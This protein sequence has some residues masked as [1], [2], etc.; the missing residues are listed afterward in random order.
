MLILFLNLGNEFLRNFIVYI[1]IALMEVLDL[2]DY[3]YEWSYKEQYNQE[4]KYSIEAFP[5][6]VK[7]RRTHYAQ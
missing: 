3:R 6:S 7:D 5:S 2:V 4:Q 1:R